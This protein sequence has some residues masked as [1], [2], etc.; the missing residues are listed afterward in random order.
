MISKNHPLKNANEDAVKK[1]SD[2]AEAYTVLIDDK[3][4]ATYTQFGARGLSE[5]V[6]AHESE[7]EWFHCRVCNH[8][9]IHIELD[10]VKTIDFDGLPG[11][12]KFNVDADKVFEDFFGGKNPFAGGY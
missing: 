1:F 2:L 11:G 3:L 5:G 12:F 9:C 4:R 8:S 10:F 6:A 7:F